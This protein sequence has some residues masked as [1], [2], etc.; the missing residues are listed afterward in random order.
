MDKIWISV[1]IV[2][3]A[4]FI[5][6]TAILV[7]L[8]VTN[9]ANRKNKKEESETTN[10]HMWLLYSTI[11]SKP[12]FQINLDIATPKEKTNEQPTEKVNSTDNNLE[13]TQE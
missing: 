5:I 3:I 6:T 4:A 1:L 10:L 9:K 2:C 11:F 13:T 8:S 7:Y 12:S